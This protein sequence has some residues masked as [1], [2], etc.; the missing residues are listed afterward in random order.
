MTSFLETGG[1]DER[2]DNAFE[3]MLDQ[4]CIRQ[5]FAFLP[6][7][8]MLQD[9]QLVCQE[10]VLPDWKGDNSGPTAISSPITSSFI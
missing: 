4:V 8:R 6:A 2:G 3:L 7:P 5:G 1:T 9:V 10:A